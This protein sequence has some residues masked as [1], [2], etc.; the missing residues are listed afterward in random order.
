MNKYNYLINNINFAFEHKLSI[1]WI[2]PN[3]IN[4]KKNKHI[5][6]YQ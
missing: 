3:Y 5:N 1:S 4:E 6:N 2:I